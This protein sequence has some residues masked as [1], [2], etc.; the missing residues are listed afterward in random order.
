MCYIAAV[1]E[2]YGP[3]VTSCTGPGLSLLDYPNH[4]EKPRV[5]VVR[6]EVDT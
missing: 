4:F 2:L 6:S 3:D 1:A 5:S